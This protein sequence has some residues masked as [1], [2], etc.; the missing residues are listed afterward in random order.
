MRFFIKKSMMEAVGNNGATAKEF[1]IQVGNST[2]A[3]RIR[4]MTSS[5]SNKVYIKENKIRKN[6][7][8]RLQMDSIT[9]SIPKK[10]ISKI[11]KAKVEMM[12]S[13]RINAK[14]KV[15]KIKKAMPKDIAKDKAKDKAKS[16]ANA[17]AKANAKANKVITKVKNVVTKV[18]KVI[19][20]VI[21]KAKAKANANAKPKAK[22]NAKAEPKAK[23]K[24]KPKAKPKKAK[25]SVK[26]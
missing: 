16:K 5:K 25:A 3:T 1:N 15:M 23:A 20:K 4:G 17:N 2:K 13:K 22:P 8:G 7:G 12:S 10:N 21:T 14:D 6:N 11:L 9:Y 19:K 24:A 18:K 26:V